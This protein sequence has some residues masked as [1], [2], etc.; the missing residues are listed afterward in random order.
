MTG[1]PGGRYPALPWDATPH[2]L[3][4]SQLRFAS[5][6]AAGER[7]LWFGIGVRSQPDPHSGRGK[8]AS[9]LY[10]KATLSFPSAVKRE[11]NRFDIRVRRER[12]FLS[13]FCHGRK[14]EASSVG[15]AHLSWPPLLGAVGTVLP[16]ERGWGRARRPERTHLL[17]EAGSGRRGD[18]AGGD[19]GE[20]G[21]GGAQEHGQGCLAIAAGVLVQKPAAQ[22]GWG[23]PAP[24]GWVQEMW[25]VLGGVRAA[26][27]CEPSLGTARCCWF[28]APSH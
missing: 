9:L 21:P 14:V 13:S 24:R 7:D 20:E 25:G 3:F 19:H 10:L 28:I 16:A 6:R 17:Q 11:Q 27:G 4:T 1:S 23:E 2:L 8:A 18:A 15:N 12:V 26:Q 22:V 5:V